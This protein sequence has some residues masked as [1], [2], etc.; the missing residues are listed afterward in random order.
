V[1]CEFLLSHPLVM[2]LAVLVLELLVLVVL[3]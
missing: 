1:T 3:V 2:W